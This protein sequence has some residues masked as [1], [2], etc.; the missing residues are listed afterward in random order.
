MGP[1]PITMAVL[2]SWRLGT[3]PPPCR[4]LCPLEL[5]HEILEDVLVVPWPLVGLG[6]ILDGEDRHLPMGHPFHRAS[7]QVH[8][9]DLEFRLRQGRRIDGKSVILRGDVD[10]PGAEVLYGLIAAAVPELQLE[11]LPA[12]GESQ[13]LVP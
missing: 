10:P 5:R 7:V 2:T 1:E 4:S 3:A 6:V 13:K 8:V 11:R 9:G 12:E